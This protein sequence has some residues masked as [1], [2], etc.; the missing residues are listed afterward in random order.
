M[1]QS[2]TNRCQHENVG[3][4]PKCQ[5]LIHWH[6]RSSH[7]HVLNH[8]R[9][10]R[11]LNTFDNTTKLTNRICFIRLTRVW[12]QDT[13][14]HDDSTLPRG[15]VMQQTFK[16]KKLKR[17]SRQALTNIKPSNNHATPMLGLEL[18]VSRID[19]RQ[20]QDGIGHSWFD[21]DIRH[22]YQNS[23]ALKMN[24]NQST[25]HT[26]VIQTQNSFG[27]IQKVSRMIKGMKANDIGMQNALQNGFSTFQFTKDLRRWKWNMEKKDF[28]RHD[29]TRLCHF[30]FL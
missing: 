14:H 2:F 29:S 20:S 19:R 5:A 3:C 22:C 27:G 28:A 24:T 25:H 13:L 17:H 6:G 30:Q 4:L 1:I 12:Q 15:I 21:T 23:L 18:I 11:I 16:R 26:F 7:F 10:K 8:L 9:S